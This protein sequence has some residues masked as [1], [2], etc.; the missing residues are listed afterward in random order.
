MVDARG[1]SVTHRSCSVIDGAVDAA[2]QLAIA[3][4]AAT[5]RSG[6]RWL[7]HRAVSSSVH[8]IPSIAS[9]GG[10]SRDHR[11]FRG[12]HRRLRVEDA[13]VSLKAQQN[14]PRYHHDQESSPPNHRPFP[15]VERQIAMP[16]RY[17]RE[18]RPRP[19]SVS[20]QTRWRPTCKQLSPSGHSITDVSGVVGSAVTITS[21]Q[22]AHQTLVRRE[23][24]TALRRG[25]CRRG[26]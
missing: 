1:L 12:L 23:S 15:D 13:M 26:R 9:S 18:G 19:H 4:E 6:R 11:V 5:P 22:I 3:S 10:D 24:G 2:V 7:H 16:P 14:E 8:V 17:G 25:W 21:P 20:R